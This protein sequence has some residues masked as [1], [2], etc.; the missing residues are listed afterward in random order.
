MYL[1]FYPILPLNPLILCVLNIWSE[2]VESAGQWLRTWFHCLFKVFKYCPSSKSN[3]RI[4]PHNIRVQKQNPNKP[5]DMDRHLQVCFSSA[6]SLSFAKGP[7]WF[8]PS[9]WK[10]SPLN[11]SVV[12]SRLGT[13]AWHRNHG[14]DC[15]IR[16]TATECPALGQK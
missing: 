6:T 16:L 7:C 5:P 3:I 14:S 12:R 13:Q 8:W 10:T 1:V 11:S 4:I 15:R 9:Y 2:I